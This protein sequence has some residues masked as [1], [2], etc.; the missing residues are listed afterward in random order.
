MSFPHFYQP[1]RVGDY[2]TP[3][4]ASA[5]AAGTQ[6]GLNPARE[7]TLRTVL[8]LVDVQ[9]DFVHT[10][11]A[12]SVPGAVDD[13]RRTIEWIFN[14]A[15]SIT[16]IAASLDSHVPIQI[17][18]PAWWIN[19]SGDHPAPYTV[20]SSSDV[21][22]GR[23]KPLYEVD[24][25]RGYVE[26]LEDAARKQL[27]IWPYHTLIGTPGHNLV[28]PLYEAIAYHAAARQAQPVFLT[29]GSVPKTEHYSILEPE[30]KVPNLPHGGLNTDFLNMLATYDR[31]YVA[32]QAKSHCVLETVS[33][34]MRYFEPK[35]EFI[36]KMMIL[37]DAMSSV[38]HPE[39]DFE[40]MA[41]AA[42]AGFESLGLHLISTAESIK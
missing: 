37:K 19:D 3:D 29:K 5:V 35:P 15:S 30:V 24:W 31:V 28:P 17:F 4:T 33:S 21:E 40:S 25:S 12:L 38:A 34:M 2:F 18:S 41:N 22:A 20:I 10:N 23:W 9:V 42:F 7:D 13:T 8:L 14:N 11:G 36:D 16:T 26:K 39:I 27:M 32:G 1:E 6:S